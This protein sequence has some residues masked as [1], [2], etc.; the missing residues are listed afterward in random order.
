MKTKE[1]LPN[2]I[3]ANIR[4]ALKHKKGVTPPFYLL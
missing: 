1:K 4:S 3:S 2:I